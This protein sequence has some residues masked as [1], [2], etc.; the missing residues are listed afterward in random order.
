MKKGKIKLKDIE[1][2]NDIIKDLVSNPEVLRMR[3]FR[4]HCDTSCFDHCYFA[5]YHCF[6]ICKKFNLDYKSATRAAMLHDLFL[7]DW[8]VKNGREGHH[9]F[10]HPKTACENASRIFDL[11]DIEKDM[12][13]S[14]MWPLTIKLP[15]Y[16]EGFVLTLV[17]KYSAI[18][19][20]VVYFFRT[21]KKNEVLKYAYLLLITFRIHR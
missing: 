18:S 21:L 12:I 10:T 20:S 7:Y 3:E 14:H 16:K 4:Q 1:E 9:A 2:F 15:K 8:R 6:N 17:D 19:E 5:A 13:L 11:N